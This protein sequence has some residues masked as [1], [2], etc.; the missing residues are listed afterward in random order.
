VKRSTNCRTSDMACSFLM[1]ERTLVAD[2]QRPKGRPVLATRPLGGLGGDVE[3]G[4]RK[5]SSPTAASESAGQEHKREDGAP[6]A[7]P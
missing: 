3:R 5:D 6:T 4:R 2:C 7:R 1:G